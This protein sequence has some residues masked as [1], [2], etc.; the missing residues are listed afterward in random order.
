VA[1]KLKDNNPARNR[2]TRKTESSLLAGILFDAAGVRYTPTHAVKGGKR[3]RYYTSQSVIQHQESA[4]IPRVPAS[5]LERVVIARVAAMFQPAEMTAMLRGKGPV[6]PAA[7]I[8]RGSHYCK[9]L[10]PEDREKFIRAVLTRV[11]VLRDAVELEISSER[12]KSIVLGEPR[13]PN[14]SD[15]DQK[16]T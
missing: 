10:Q 13:A 16:F 15:D 3:Y 14:D 1:T 9:K 7:V 6:V 12:M 11:T 4:G 5:E 8:S 2:S